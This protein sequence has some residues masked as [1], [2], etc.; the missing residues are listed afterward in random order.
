MAVVIEWNDGTIDQGPTFESV[1]QVITESQWH[2]YTPSQMLEVLSDR[3]WAMHQGAIDPQLPLEDFFAKLAEANMIRV[4][5][6]APEAVPDGGIG[7]G[8][9]RRPSMRERRARG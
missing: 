8:T 9:S 3:A 7:R 6:W 4:I 2:E 1:L 5:E